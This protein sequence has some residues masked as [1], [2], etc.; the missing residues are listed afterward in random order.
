MATVYIGKSTIEKL[1]SEAT[2]ENST[3]KTRNSRRQQ[4]FLSVS[5][6]LRGQRRGCDNR[7]IVVVTGCDDCEGEGV[8]I[9]G[10]WLIKGD[11]QNVTWRR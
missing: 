10:E 1:L 4:K 2:T 7:S 8:D 11:V 6:I 3:G 9:V 5:G